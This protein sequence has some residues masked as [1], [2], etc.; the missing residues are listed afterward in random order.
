MTGQFQPNNIPPTVPP[1]KI[2]LPDNS[3]LPPPNLDNKSLLPNDLRSP[4]SQSTPKPNS[5][6]Q[7]ELPP[8]S[9]SS[10]NQFNAELPPPSNPK[11]KLDNPPVKSQ[12][13]DSVQIDKKVDRQTPPYTHVAT[14]TDSY[15]SIAASAY[16]DGQWF[17]ALHHHNI[18]AK[19]EKRMGAGAKIDVPTREWLKKTYPKLVPDSGN[20]SQSRVDEIAKQTR[21]YTVAKGETLF[22][23]AAEQLGQASRY[24]DL[25]KLNHDVLPKDVTHL[26]RLKTGLRIILPVNK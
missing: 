12:K 25:M 13:N 26:T 15:W 11:L 14:A 21:M 19:N 7:F 16:G 3:K 5:D 23:I 2:K 18:K 24:T 20:A 8:P 17:R 4:D 6:S 22:S 1:E 10:Q 9:D